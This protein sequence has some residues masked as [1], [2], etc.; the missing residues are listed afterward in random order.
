MS[1]ENLW[2]AGSYE[3]HRPRY[4]DHFMDRFTEILAESGIELTSASHLDIATGTG[5]LLHPFRKLFGS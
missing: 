1:H 3:K 4:P 5:Q 2:P